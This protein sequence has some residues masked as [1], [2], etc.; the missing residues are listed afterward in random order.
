MQSRADRRQ[1]LRL[2]RK[3]KIDIRIIRNSME[4]QGH[5]VDLSQGG[6][7]VSTQYWSSVKKGD[8]TEMRLFLPP[9]FSGQSRTLVLGGLARVERVES[10]R[11]GIALQFI[12]ELRTFKVSADTFYH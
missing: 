10:D 2:T 9:D 11:E 6:A 1:Y 7:F 3:F 12:K 8:E 4:I 5:T